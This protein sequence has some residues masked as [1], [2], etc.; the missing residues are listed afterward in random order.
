MSE[1]DYSNYYEDWL[2]DNPAEYQGRPE[3]DRRYAQPFLPGGGEG[4][5]QVPLPTT[6]TQTPPP[7]GGKTPAQI[8]AEGREYDAQH[9]LFGGYFD[10][11]T[12]KWVNGSPRNGPGDTGGGDDFNFG[13]DGFTSPGFDGPKFNAPV[14]TPGEFNYREFEGFDPFVQ[15]TREQIENEPGYAFARD[16]GL[17]AA[18]NSAAARGTLRT[19]GTIK[20][21]IGWGNRFAEQNAS[22]VFDRSYNLWGQNNQNKLQAWGANRDLAFGAFDRNESARQGAFDRN[23]Q[24]AKD[25]FFYNEFEPARMTFDDAYRRWAK[26]IDA[27]TTLAGGGD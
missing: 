17:K 5:V 18:E 2:R 25:S 7:G 1:R 9:G 10:T 8:E 20:D 12:G 27:T 11:V 14:Y 6:T 16:E 15:P 4:G 13:G 21:L 23:Y 22:R 24:G 19:G 26:G 3:D